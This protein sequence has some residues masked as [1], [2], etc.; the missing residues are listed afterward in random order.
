MPGMKFLL[1][2]LVYV[3]PAVVLIAWLNC[4]S[5]NENYTIQ[6]FTTANGLPH[7]H[8]TSIA[9]DKHGFI[10]ISTWDGLSRYDGYEFKNYFH[11]P[12]DSTSIPYFT[13]DQVLVDRYNSIW[14]SGYPYALARYNPA[15]D[16]FIQVAARDVKHIMLDQNDE[17]WFFHEN[18]LKKWNENIN[19]F[20]IYTVEFQFVSDQAELDY[21]YSVEIDN[22]GNVWLFTARAYDDWK[23]FKSSEAKG[24]RIIFNYA[25]SIPE[26]LVLPQYSGN[27][28]KFLPFE[29]DSGQ[30]WLL[31]GYGLFRFDL[32]HKRFTRY[33]G[34]FPPSGFQGLPASSSGRLK[35]ALFWYTG[36]GTQ[37]LAG[38]KIT[39]NYV[40]TLFI[41]QQG[42]VWLT[43]YD[44]PAISGGL[45]RCIPVP[46][47]FT[48]YF[49]ENPDNGRVTPFFPV[50]KDK[51]GTIWA[52]PR[53]KNLMYR[54]RNDG[55]FIA[56][57]PLDDSNWQS[58]IHPR[59]LLEDESGLWIG[60]NNSYLVYHEFRSGRYELVMNTYAQAQDDYTNPSGFVHL[61]KDGDDLIIFSYH[62]IYRYNIKLKAVTLLNRIDENKAI[63][64]MQKDGEDGWIVGYAKG[65]VRYFD[66]DFH[67]VSEF[68]V[69]SGLF[70][71]EAVCKG[72]NNVI[73]A[74]L[75]GEGIARIDQETGKSQLLT[76][77]DGL[78][79]NTA[80]SILRDKTGNL[81]ITT[82]QGISRY[83]PE[84]HQ[85]RQF[86]KSEGLQIEEFNSDGLYQSEEG[87]M[88][89]AG[90][91]GVVRFRP[92][93]INLSS[94]FKQMT[95]LVITEFHVSGM[96]RYFS[97]SII[98]LDTLRLQKGDDNFR[99]GFS[100]L[101]FRDAEKIRYRYRLIEEEDDY[102]ETNF[103][104]RFVS[105]ANLTPGTYR[106]MVE[107]TNRDGEWVSKTAIA[108]VIPPFY[109]QTWWFRLLVSAGVILLL[110][111]L[112]FIYIRQIRLAAH[113]KQSELRL[114]SLRGQMNPHFIFNS[115]NSINYFIAQN[116]RLSANRYI[117]DFSR[118]IR[119][120]LGNMSSDFI[121]F[122][123]ELES[124]NDYLRLEHLRFG[125]KFEYS[126]EV[127][128][129]LTDE[130]LLVFPG[131]VQPFVENA[132][133]HGVRGLE[134]KKG[135][136]RVNF[137]RDGNY[138]LR[139]T[140]TDDG[141]G[142]K[143]SH[144]RKSSLHTHNSRGL[145][146]AR[147]RLDIVNSLMQSAYQIKVEDVFPDREETG[148]RVIL[149]IPAKYI[150]FKTTIL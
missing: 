136:V 94:E 95:P 86:G 127:A 84:T 33:S 55:A 37:N 57:K 25:G 78:S 14:V 79:N 66:R 28:I 52:P 41:D 31:S 87:E 45:A 138:A 39:E 91:G 5:G 118:L 68:T 16:N 140:V 46:A 114:E 21:F 32:P 93:E 70:N 145:R 143:L 99:A 56:D 26:E 126:V 83:N 144:Q 49:T 85:F 6:T 23:L 102:T 47:W 22:G 4:A 90:M 58:N 101:N 130:G 12:G 123:R 104:N 27:K 43:F 113:Q 67:L 110:A 36:A 61:S 18:K 149:D 80:Y 8:I 92:D 40:S 42:V 30:Y 117:A 62:A 96:P 60:Y 89:F 75:L 38:D 103:R 100:C 48:H 148:T 34:M 71:V 59:S 24:D 73:W 139:C 29:T 54:V 76:T 125:D 146:I 74:A 63:Y 44:D 131:M 51:Y 82:N 121:P 2:L 147:E 135:M 119:T 3:L 108:I 97:K 81:W 64:S 124:L 128:E 109:Y 115:L 15:D 120:I 98:E 107:A 17:L 35:D 53:N 142:R 106:L 72:D 133:W 77:A 134:G 129:G 1:K 137:H 11:R 141:I 10:W 19:A 111:G 150:N 9:Q 20:D 112:V 50:L 122:S 116:D 69:G 65:T 88:F 7:N 13:V 105:Y 132:I